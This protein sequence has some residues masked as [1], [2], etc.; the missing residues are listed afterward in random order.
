MAGLID[1]SHCIKL[2]G[3]NHL[4][5]MLFNVANLVDAMRKFAAG[6]NIGKNHV[7]CVGKQRLREPVPFTRLPG[8]ME[9]HHRKP[10][11][12][13]SAVCAINLGAPPSPRVCFCG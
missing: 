7:S 8:Y 5:G 4:L 6:G 1:Q 10:Y 12:K 2:A 3:M 13:H 11:S 9:F